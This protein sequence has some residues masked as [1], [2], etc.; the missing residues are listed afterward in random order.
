[1]PSRN[2]LK[3]D[4]PDSFYHVYARGHSRTKVFLDQEDYAT[5]LSLFKRYLSAKPQHSLAGAPYPHLFNAIELACFCL[6]SN[7]FHLLLYQ[8]DEGSMQR[9]MRGVLTS[10]SRYFNKKYQRS[11]ALFESSYKASLISD[12]RYLDHI[13]RYIHLNR[14]DWE[15]SPYSSIDFYLGKRK[16]SWVRPERI[17]AMFSNANDY[18]QFVAD[19]AG[20]KQ[21]LDEIK[22]ELANNIK[23]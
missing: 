13:T 18:H 17:L 6:M 7:H 16:A 10:Y 20:H 14:K 5:F 19:Y 4:I 12:Q 23:Q 22:H 2:V 8:K 9:L 1:M 21:M 11:G 15:H 3:I